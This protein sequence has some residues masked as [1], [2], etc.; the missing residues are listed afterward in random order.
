MFKKQ[1]LNFM[2]INLSP[3]NVILL[4]MKEELTIKRTNGA[5]PDFQLLISHLDHELWNELNEDQATY[6][7]YNKVPDIQTA[8]VLYIDKKPIA[9]GCFK[10]YNRDTV[11][12]KRMFV[13]KEYRGKGLSKQILDELETWAAELAFQY[14]ILETSIHF[15]VARKLYANAGYAMIENYDQYAGL[16]ES[17]CMKKEL[18]KATGVS[19]FKNLPGIEYF[20][21]E[22]DFIK[23][24]IGCIPMIVRFKMDKAGIKL[25]LVEWSKFSLEERKELAKK[26]CGNEEEAMLYN[27]YLAG[28]INKYTGKAATALTV[29]KNP[30]WA[31][32]HAVPEMLNEKLK[33]F[34]WHISLQQWKGLSNLQRFALLKLCK[35]GHESKN[36]PKAMK[37]FKLI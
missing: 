19:D 16:I 36:F 29:D 24:N 15:E 2:K 13:E 11:E 4:S 23:K 33:Q 28:L 27:D 1:V 37:E 35:A 34:G 17:V 8:L 3:S 14:A 10:K 18:I 31:D 12:I 20:L 25:N 21:F 26:S 30:V 22:E 6:D 9:S 5:D 7:Q 32:I